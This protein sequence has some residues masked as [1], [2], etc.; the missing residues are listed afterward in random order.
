MIAIGSD[1]GKLHIARISDGN[2]VDFCNMRT[3]IRSS[4]A[5]QD[6]TVFLS[7]KD[8]SIRALR[9]KTNGNPDEEWVHQPDEDDPIDRGRIEDC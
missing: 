4:L 8:K 6:D 2:P 9:I 7:A 5:V 3:E 1:D